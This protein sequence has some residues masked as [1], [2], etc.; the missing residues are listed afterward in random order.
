MQADAGL[1][2]NA[3]IDEEEII[4]GATSENIESQDLDPLIHTYEVL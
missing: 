3:N 1:F 4:D 2:P